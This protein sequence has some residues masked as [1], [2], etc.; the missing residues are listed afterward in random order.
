MSPKVLDTHIHLWPATATAQTDHSWMTPGHRLATRHGI[1]D[2]ISATQSN[3]HVQPTGF[4]YVETDRFLPNALP[5]TLI[6]ASEERKEA[7]LKEYARAPLQE[8]EFLRRIVEDRPQEGDGFEKRDGI[9]MKGAV[10]WAPFDVSPDVFKL[11][12]RI[13]EEVSGPVLWE[14]VVGFRY[15]VQGIKREQ[16]MRRLVLSEEWLANLLYLRQGREGRGWVFDIGVD[17]HGGGVWQAE[18]AAEMIARVR[19]LE[20]DDR[21]GRV[22]FVLSKLVTF[23]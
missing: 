19:D 21:Q 6:S 9:F 16:E 7:A 4:V 3:S 1:S 18:V 22:R 17:T 5:S 2:Y 12:L 11:Y 20:G 10:I 13:A 14:R 23:V 8:L 15:L